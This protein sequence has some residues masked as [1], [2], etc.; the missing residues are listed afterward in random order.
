MTEVRESFVQ[1]LFRVRLDPEPMR[2]IERRPAP[3]RTVEQHAA[4]A[5][6]G[7]GGGAAGAAPPQAPA[8][9]KPAA[10]SGPRVGRNDPCPCG[11]G[12]KYKKCHGPIDEGV[13]ARG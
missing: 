11:S 10:R 8:G 6:F 1:R 5:T 2:G 4:P 9:A 3:R 7:G 12:K 13:E